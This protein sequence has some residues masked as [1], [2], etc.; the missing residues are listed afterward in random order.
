MIRD[1]VTWQVAALADM[2]RDIGETES[3]LD[4]SQDSQR[5]SELKKQLDNRTRLLIKSNP[6]VA[7]HVAYLWAEVTNRIDGNNIRLNWAKDPHYDEASDWGSE[8]THLPDEAALARL[9]LGSFLLRVDFRLV[10]PYLSRDDTDFYVVDNSVRKEWVSRLPMI[11][12]TSWK[13]ALYGTM[14][15]QAPV[16]KK[17]DNP[18]LARIF[19]DIRDNDNGQQGCLYF[20]P[21]FFRDYIIGA[22]VINPHERD[23][24]LGIKPITLECVKSGAKGQLNLLYVN[25]YETE[26][27][28]QP[29]SLSDLSG[30]LD[31]VAKLL[32][33]YGIGAKTSA[34]YG[35][36]EVWGGQLIL[37]MDGIE[38][39]EIDEPSGTDP[40]HA[41]ERYL[42][43]PFRLAPDF[44]DVEDKL[45]DE[46][47]Y[48]AR[49]EAKGQKYKKPDAQLYA[50]AQRWWQ[51]NQ[52]FIQA[53]P[54]SIKEP[55][56]SPCVTRPFQ[57]IEQ[58]QQHIVT[59]TGVTL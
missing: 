55:P 32:A 44:R 17:Q 28:G 35:L 33:V 27:N 12:A 3:E 56:Q 11:A 24:G 13:G 37:H 43:T 31:S 38:T 50:K 4:S 36:C 20:F 46:E 7:P 16:E 19:G 51:R 14:W 54:D 57:T 49:I 9:P 25:S 40:E 48:K 30:I 58:L 41:P 1:F 52:A 42:E 8:F 5:K 2:L 26:G 47:A 53:E 45:I 6:L 23:T 10:K 59:L 21:T 34:G 18:Q 39:A 29:K 22:E 15:R